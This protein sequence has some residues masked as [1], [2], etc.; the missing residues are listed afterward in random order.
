MTKKHQE[1][2][3]SAGKFDY[4]QQYNAILESEMV[5]T[6]EVGTDNSPMSPRQYVTVKILVQENYS[7]SFKKR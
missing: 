1:V 2:I 7:V 5:S 4:Q 6:P 3:K